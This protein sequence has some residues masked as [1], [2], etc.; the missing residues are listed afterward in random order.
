MSLSRF[1]VL[2]ALAASPLCAE[3]APSLPSWMAGCW[4]QQSGDRWTEECWTAPR[5]GIMLGSGR[6]GEGERLGSWEV[7]QI[8]RD[9]DDGS[10][11]FYGA[12]GG[13]NR[14]VFQGRSEA[15][16]VTFINPAHD[17]PQRIHNS[18]DGEELV[19]EVSLLDGS[20]ASRWIYRR[21]K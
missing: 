7:M 14:T 15:G 8:V 12:P 21:A 10:L 18:R 17:Y 4:E 6:S 19:A 16:A 2:L 1:G 3:E 11:T 9:A 13:A 20:K 5:A